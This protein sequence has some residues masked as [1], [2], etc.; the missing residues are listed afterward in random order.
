MTDDR[1]MTDDLTTTVI[2]TFQDRDQEYP[3]AT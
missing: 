3:S 1:Q 2:A